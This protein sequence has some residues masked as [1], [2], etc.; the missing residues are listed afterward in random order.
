VIKVG[1]AADEI[2]FMR[3]GL[4]QKA[5]GRGGGNNCGQGM[6]DTGVVG[7][8]GVCPSSQGLIQELEVRVKPYEDRGDTRL[9]ITYQQTHIVPILGQ[10]KGRKVIESGQDMMNLHVH[11]TGLG[12]AMTAGNKKRYI[13]AGVYLFLL[14]LS[15]GEISLMAR[16]SYMGN[17]AFPVLFVRDDN[18]FK[19]PGGCM[20]ILC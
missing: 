5:A 17:F 9:G 12:P 1:V 10:R 7:D 15:Q 19:E 6:E 18:V 4:F 20:Q 3:Q 16:S 2:D 8:N 13:P 14:R 11:V